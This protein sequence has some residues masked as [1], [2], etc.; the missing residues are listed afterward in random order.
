MKT[1]LSSIDQDQLKG[2]MK[3]IRK[4]IPLGFK[5]HSKP[6]PKKFMPSQTPKEAGALTIVNQEFNH[7]RSQVGTLGG[8]NHFIEFQQA[9]D[10]HIWVMVHSGSRNLGFKVANHYN[11][12][13]VAL[14][15]KSKKP[16]PSSWQ[17]A[18]LPLDSSQGKNY[19]AEMNYCVLFAKS[20][21]EVMMRRIQEI[22]E[23]IL[24]GKISF[25][26]SF[27][28]AHN[29]AALELHFGKKVMV[30][31]KGATRA[32]PGELGIIPGSQGTNSYIVCGKG[33]PESFQSCSHGAG[34][35]LGRKQA[36][37]QLD[38]EK[39]KRELDQKGILHAIRGRRDLEEA[40]G[41]YKDIEQVMSLQ[42]DLV[43]IQEILQP[44][45]VIKG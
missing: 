18:A 19:L 35:K 34:R 12:I 29:Y 36:Q 42:Q 30:H 3:G 21:R 43:E 28:V 38:L 22:M 2:V 26:P 23:E 13:A 6:L 27:D 37:K 17:L 31:R 8:G 1:S 45:A 11:K 4:A 7:G 9:A 41:A 39:E 44:L 10:R 20:N 14:N 25:E 16:L 24:H 32:F 5:H 33:N 40:A 15:K